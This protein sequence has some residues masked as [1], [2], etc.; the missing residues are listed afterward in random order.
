M[1]LLLES[2]FAFENTWIEC[3]GDLA[4]Y[5][6]AVNS[7]ERETWACVARYWYLQASDRN[8]NI[9]RIQH[10]LAVLARPD[11]LQQLFHYTKSLVSVHPFPSAGESILFLFDPLLNGSGSY[12]QLV[13]M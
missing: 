3:L 10:H 12:G 6:M 5:S 1:T 13:L 2:V 11:M 8:P 4:R 9:G 7:P